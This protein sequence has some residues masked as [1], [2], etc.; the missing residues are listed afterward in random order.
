MNGTGVGNQEGVEFKGVSL[1]SLF[2]NKY[3][4]AKV[5]D[6]S[7]HAKLTFDKVSVLDQP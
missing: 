1:F 2:F 5:A 6:K 7:P 3:G 4:N